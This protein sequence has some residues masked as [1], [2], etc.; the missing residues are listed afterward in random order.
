MPFVV[1]ASVAAVWGLSDEEHPNADSARQRLESDPAIVPAIWWFELRNTFLVNERRGRVT[2]QETAAFL[3]VLSRLPIRQ[4]SGP[5]ELRLLSL[6]RKHRL[7]A[8]DAAYLELAQREGVPLAS[9]DTDL[10]HAAQ[11]EGVPVLGAA[12]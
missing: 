9:L 10:I 7:T 12:T 2:P 11:A 5:E 1:D 8:Y 4:D 6:A 3:R